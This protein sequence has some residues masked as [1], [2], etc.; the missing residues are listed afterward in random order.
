ME[1]Y[2][3]I[4]KKELNLVICNNMD[5]P[6]GYCA[7]WSKSDR[8]RQMSYMESREQD[9]QTSNK[10]KTLAY[11]TYERHFRWKDTQTERYKKRCFMK[12]KTKKSRSS[13]TYTRQNRL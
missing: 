11:A 5:G 10:N 8:E 1:Y 12:M 4:K 2:S 6:R 9:K 7:E 3:A 13:N